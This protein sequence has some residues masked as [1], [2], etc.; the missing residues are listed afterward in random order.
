[1]LP[2]SPVVRASGPILNPGRP[3]ANGEAGQSAE[4]AIGLDQPDEHADDTGPGSGIPAFDASQSATGRPVGAAARLCI[5]PRFDPAPGSLSAKAASSRPEASSGKQFVAQLRLRME[6][7]RTDAIGVMQEDDRGQIQVDRGDLLEN[8]KRVAA[9]ELQSAVRPG[10]LQA[11]DSAVAEV[12]N[13]VRGMH[14]RSSI[15]RELI[16]SVA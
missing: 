2:R 5:P 1:M 8:S 7:D 16:R 15:K 3:L 10:H 12:E 13:D 6:L 4:S 9:A 14:R 11:Q